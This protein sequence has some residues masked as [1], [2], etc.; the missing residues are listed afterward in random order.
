MKRVACCAVMLSFLTS[1]TNAEEDFPWDKCGLELVAAMLTV[2]DQQCPNVKVT[3]KGHELMTAM[4]SIGKSECK[5]IAASKIR[6]DIRTMPNA[7]CMV[8]PT[9]TNKMKSGT[10]YVERR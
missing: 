10:V 1:P 7:W 4:S 5:S 3:L 6:D 8:Y 2:A 9:M